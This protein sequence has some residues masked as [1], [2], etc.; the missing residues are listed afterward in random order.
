MLRIIEEIGL[1]QEVIKRKFFIECKNFWGWK[2]L[3]KN[4]LRTQDILFF[5]SYEEAESYIFKKSNNCN[6]YKN[7]NTYEIIEHTFS[8]C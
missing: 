7:N 8:F 2:K 5:E 4:E 1:Y 3:T 6:I